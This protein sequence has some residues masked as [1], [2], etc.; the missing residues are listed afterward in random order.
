MA[1]MTFDAVIC[2]GGNKALM[3]AMYL[4]RYAGM[5]C[6]IF[7]RRHE[8][9]G[10]LATE[11]M[12][13]PGFRGNTHA[14]ILL[15]WYYA[16]IYRDFPDFWEWGG[17]IDQYRCSD[18]SIFL[19]NQT[20]LSIYSQKTDPAQEKTAQEIAR[21][22]EKDA[23]TWLKIVK[24]SQMEEFQAITVDS[25]LNPH[26][27][28][29]RPEFLQRQAAAMPLLQDAGLDP[30]PYLTSSPLEAVKMLF[31]SPELQYTVL[32]FFPSGVFNVRDTTKG[33]NVLGMAGT[34]T[35]LGFA[36][37]GTHMIAHACHQMLVHAGCKFFTHAEV[38][39][40]LH[41]GTKATG[42]ELADGTQVEARKL[43]VT[44]G[45]SAGQLLELVGRD[46]FGDEICRKV[47]ALSTS[48]IGN[49]MWYS[50]ALHEA[51]Q[52]KAEDFNPDIHETF[53]LGLAPSPDVEHIAR[54]CDAANQGQI[55]PLDDFNPVVWC[56]SL[57]DSSYA[58]PGKH[59]AQHE[60]QGP[61]ATDL[62][63][64]DWLKLKRKHADDMISFWGRFA[65]NMSW[66][67]V[68]GVDTN[69]P[70]DYRRMKN[71]APHGNFAGI[72]QTPSQSG[73]NR[74]TPELANHRTPIENLYCTGGYWHVG[75]E[76]SSAQAYNCYKIIA[77]DM[78]LGKPWEEQGKEE[79][80][81]LVAECGA[82][83]QRMRDT[84][85]RPAS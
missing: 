27:W 13:A 41:S 77:S 65:P 75:G 25:L 18:G 46:V 5:S 47:D 80:G 70:F 55:P 29:A 22:S 24:L 43:V 73:A 7:E 50:F 68:I 52:Y 44:A 76:A 67:N 9:G 72:D 79:P 31:E 57:V 38:A 26:E 42:I 15:P 53:W 11:E 64:A 23:E 28:Q 48:N 33:M 19:N 17:Q 32:R 16:P 62:S 59:V 14:N 63:E 82:L 81:S 21:F 54:E 35:T 12:S 61:R 3:L 84:F 60:M 71:L 4:S 56:H 37:G 34:L 8:V 1:D 85:P 69:S 74:P 36:R 30:I 10:G 6:G 20:C 83:I 78:D 39:K 51:P 2:G 66:D 49:I 45:L 58:P 40:V